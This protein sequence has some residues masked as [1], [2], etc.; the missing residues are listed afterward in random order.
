MLRDVRAL[1]L[2]LLL[3]LSVLPAACRPAPS[4]G[5]PDVV[6]LLVDDLGWADVGYHQAPDAAQAPHTP[7]ID[8]LAASG[9]RLERVYAQPSCTPTRAGLF[10][11]RHPARMGIRS[12]LGI[13]NQAGV[14]LDERILA[15]DFRDAGYR[16]ALIGKWHLG[17]VAD[18]EHPNARG[19]DHFYG[20]LGGM[21]DYAQHVR[22]GGVLDW[23]RN[24]ES[25]REP[26]YATRLIAAEAGRVLDDDRDT[27]LFL[28]VSFNA[29]HAP[30]HVAPGRKPDPEAENQ[31][32][33][34]YVTM[35][36]EL[37]LAIG[38]VL[39][40][41]ADR[42]RE[43]VI[44]FVSDN[45]GAPKSGGSNVPLRG[46]KF[47]AFEGAVR[48][49]AIVRYDGQVPA[50]AASDQVLACM[51]LLPTL[52]TAAGVPLEVSDERPLD[53]ESLWDEL[54]SGTTRARPALLFV[55]EMPDESNYAVLD[56]RWKLV[57]RRQQ[58]GPLGR[59]LYDLEGEGGELTDVTDAHP[60]TA[61]RLWHVLRPWTR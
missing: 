49:P 12:N 37:D 14:P 2:T 60:D 39:D 23:Q 26:G 56:G 36:E 52:A 27:P 50:G 5:P 31:K 46:R 13:G 33:A 48:V 35:V 24:G 30:L 28:C 51:D 21:I 10:T 38:E 61:E 43:S 11:G 54:A 41:L 32:R 58:D 15:Q 16:T 4:G 34:L 40:A 17:E 55:C 1:P 59:R 57:A 18:G 42:G 47:Q 3:A 45:G 25:L 9:L 19:F 7:R 20:H 6:V 22:K 53:G 44:L 29:P 8:A